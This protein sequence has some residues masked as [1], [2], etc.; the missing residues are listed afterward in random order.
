MAILRANLRTRHAT[1]TVI[2]IFYGHHHHLVV[3]VV[4]VIIFHIDYVATL[5]QVEDV[6]GYD[7]R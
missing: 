6:P 3:F 7:E 4:E 2:R 1:N 5:N